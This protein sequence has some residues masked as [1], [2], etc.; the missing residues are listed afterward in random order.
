MNRARA[1][2]LRAPR[3]APTLAGLTLDLLDEAVRRLRRAGASY[4]DA[5]HVSDERE[6]V[7]MRDG[8]V[9]RLF[10]GSSEGVGVRAIV[11]GAWGFAARAGSGDFAAALDEACRE[12]LRTARAA[13]SLR[14]AKSRG[15]ELAEEEPQRGHFATPVAEHPFAVPLDEKLALLDGVTRALRERA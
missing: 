1:A 8:R 7:A 2:T 10:R 11:D 5:R 15:V 3:R 12:A 13:A 14:P 4:A 6:Q 9:E